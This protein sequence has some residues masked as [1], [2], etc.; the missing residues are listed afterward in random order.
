MF[1][2]EMVIITSVKTSLILLNGE[3]GGR[4]HIPKV[5]FTFFHIIVLRKETEKASDYLLLN[6]VQGVFYE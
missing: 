2:L 6:R 1:S 4:L 5:I 3:E